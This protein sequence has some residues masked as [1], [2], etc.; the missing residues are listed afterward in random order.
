MI[1]GNAPGGQAGSSSRIENYL[2]FPLGISGQELADRAFTQAEKFGAQIAI[3]HNVQKLHCQ[4]SPFQIELDDG[5]LL[6]ARTLVVASGSRYRKLDLPGATRFEGHGIYYWAT[7]VEAPMC[8]S[9]D[10]AVVGGGNSAGQAA[11]F[12]SG[13]AKHV[14]LLVRGP[15]LRK[16]MS[17]YL[18]A[19]IEHS[20]RI[21]LLDHTTIEDVEGHEGLERVRWRNSSSGISSTHDIGQLFIM[22]GADPNTSWLADCLMMDEKSF[23]L[24][25]ARVAKRWPLARAPFPFETSVPGIFAVGDVRSFSVKRVASAVGEGSMAIQFVHQVLAMP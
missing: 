6:R 15:S 9:N 3:A 18:I 2:G 14:Y 17:R 22:T 10:I 24:T 16:T 19:Q 1:E 5:R 11:V 20:P 21:T 8:V 12:L 4:Q 13:I 23:V 25:G 7:H